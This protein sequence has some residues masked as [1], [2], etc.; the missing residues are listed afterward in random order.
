MTFSE[1]IGYKVGSAV[2][3]FKHWKTPILV[4]II[5]VFA[6]L[7]VLFFTFFDYRNEG[8][9]QGIY[10]SSLGQY[11]IWGLALFIIFKFREQIA[12]FFESPEA[13]HLRH[14]RK[15]VRDLKNELKE[16]QTKDKVIRDICSGVY[17]EHKY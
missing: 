8:M 2:V 17:N 3:K 5:S 14:L 9:Y 15:E 7:A 13:Y 12:E 10:I 11:I 4:K 16:K 1:K 6:V